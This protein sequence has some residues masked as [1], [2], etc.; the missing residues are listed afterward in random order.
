M[1][2]AVKNRGPASCILSCC[3]LVRQVEQS[4]L[5]SVVTD[6]VLDLPLVCSNISK[7]PHVGSGGW[8]G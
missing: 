7:V 5:I 1:A 2:V 3:F 6:Q 8:E 4:F